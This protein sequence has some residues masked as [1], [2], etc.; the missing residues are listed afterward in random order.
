MLPSIIG[1]DGFHIWIWN[2][3]RFR[4]IQSN[5]LNGTIHRMK[6]NIVAIIHCFWNRLNTLGMI[7]INNDSFDRFLLSPNPNH[8]LVFHIYFHWKY[9][10]SNCL[11][12]S[13]MAMCQIIVLN[14]T[15][16]ELALSKTVV[17]QTSNVSHSHWL[18]VSM[19]WQ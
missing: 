8:Y 9:I 7:S 11:L 12:S 6:R 3:Y 19:V 17:Q 18:S 14:A 4:F 15:E 10:Q 2:N 5:F 1:I 13:W 16:C